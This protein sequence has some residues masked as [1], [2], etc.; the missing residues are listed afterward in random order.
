[1]IRRVLVPLDGSPTAERVL[2]YARALARTF[3]ADIRLLRVLDAEAA[4]EA[5]PGYAGSP[6]D[7]A[8]WRLAGREAEA[9][10]EA[11]AAELTKAGLRSEIEVGFGKPEENIL[12]AVR[13]HAVDLVVLTVRGRCGGTAATVVSSSGISVLIIRATAPAASASDIERRFR[14][15]LAA[16][17]GS[18]RAEWGLCLAASLARAHA[19]E[20][21][22]AQVVVP[23]P[24]PLPRHAVAEDAD[25]AAAIVRRN[26]AVAE[27]YLQEMAERLGVPG[28]TVRSAVLQSAS[29]AQALHELGEHEGA[30]LL[31]LSAHGSSGSSF[32]PYGSVS[33]A[34][35]SFARLPLLIFQDLP[36][37]AAAVS[38]AV[39]PAPSR[40]REA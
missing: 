16:V 37:D 5:G 28:L 21:L 1:M 8:E 29:V 36:R 2:P 13:T 19:A 35:L 25:L 34:L 11:L 23:P 6:L 40:P 26:R 30:D 15:V 18:M 17:D 12:Q 7:S 9:Y 10:L 20:L 4:V 14:L 3:Q 39:E 27:Q 33:G 22:I 38:P 24:M 32:W 31:V